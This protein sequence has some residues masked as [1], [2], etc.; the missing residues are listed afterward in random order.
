MKL[1]RLEPNPIFGPPY[2]LA[3]MVWLDRLDEGLAEWS[4]A[5]SSL[6]PFQREICGLDVWLEEKVLSLVHRVG[7]PFPEIEDGFERLLES[8]AAFDGRTL[9]GDG[10]TEAWRRLA[11][12]MRGLGAEAD[13][14]RAEVREKRELVKENLA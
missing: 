4:V 8:A 11:A 3:Q 1:P 5:V 10:D 9:Q 6:P 13:R 12:E 14:L 7:C 2:P